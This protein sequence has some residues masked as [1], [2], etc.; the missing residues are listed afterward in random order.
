[1]SVL[2][3]VYDQGDAIEHLFELAQNRQQPHKAGAGCCL[4]DWARQQQ[5]SRPAHFDVLL[6]HYR[7]D[8]VTDSSLPQGILKAGTVTITPDKIVVEHF[9][10]DMDNLPSGEACSDVALRW[11]KERLYLGKLFP[12]LR[13][14]SGE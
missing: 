7:K 2:P 12:P 1:M 9:T 6:R 5:L 13:G 4:C 8:V 14:G 3:N 11:A 10:F